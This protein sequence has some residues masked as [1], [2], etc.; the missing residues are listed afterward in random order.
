M[1]GSN[2]QTARSWPEPKWDVQPTEPPRRPTINIFDG[3]LLSCFVSA[4]SLQH[5]SQWIWSIL[6]CIACQPAIQSLDWKG[7]QRSFYPEPHSPLSPTCLCKTDVHTVYLFIMFVQNR[8]LKTGS[9]CF[10][11][12]WYSKTRA[13]CFPPQWGVRPP[14]L[15]VRQ[16][17]LVRF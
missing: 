10:S 14:G 9:F 1:W 12:S 17:D 13:D 6:S 15:R 7:T 4:L 2:S 16:P 8:M 3:L 5:H 11:I